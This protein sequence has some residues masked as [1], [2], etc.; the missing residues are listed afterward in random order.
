[1]TTPLIVEDTIENLLHEWLN[2]GK[3]YAVFMA[4]N[5]AFVELMV[6]TQAWLEKTE[7]EV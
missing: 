3:N 1:M 2:W 6:R 7:S 5:Q 4:E